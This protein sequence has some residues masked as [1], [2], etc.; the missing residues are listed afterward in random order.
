MKTVKLGSSDIQVSEIC[1]GSMTWG[2]QNSQEEAF[3]QLDY[4]VNERQINF[5]DTAEMYA[6]PPS[7]ETSGL[8]ETY[9]GNWF[10][11][12][13]VPEFLGFVGLA[14]SRQM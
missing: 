2:Q 7:K 1:L 14:P 6:V 5:I 3:E 10:A 8:T 13:R 4:A 9:I 12:S 11:A